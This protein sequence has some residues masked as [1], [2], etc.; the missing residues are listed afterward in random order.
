MEGQREALRGRKDNP[1]FTYYNVINFITSLSF[2]LTLIVIALVYLTF[3][4]FGFMGS[5]T[6][7]D[8][9]AVLVMVIIVAL[10]TMLWK[11]KTK[12]QSLRVVR[13]EVIFTIVML[14]LWMGISILGIIML[15]GVCICVFN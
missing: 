9:L 3:Y 15:K 1:V 7:H 11:Y 6:G 4:M 5:S 8:I 10:P 2:Y 12:S 13:K 14:F